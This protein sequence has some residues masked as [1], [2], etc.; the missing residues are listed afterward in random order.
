MR[1]AR[2]HLQY[3]SYLLRGGSLKQRT[4]TLTC[5]PI[6]MQFGV[7]G[8]RPMGMKI[9]CDISLQT[10][11]NDFSGGLSFRKIP[12][13]SSEPHKNSS[14]LQMKSSGQGYTHVQ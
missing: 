2:R 14:K 1:F 11:R 5:G 8:W 6:W 4:L 9:S 3:Q 7:R 10:R 12:Q 13:F